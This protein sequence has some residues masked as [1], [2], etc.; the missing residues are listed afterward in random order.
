[1]ENFRKVELDIIVNASKEAVWDLTFN[2]FGEVNNFNPLIEG[3]HFTS[4]SKGEVGCERQCDLDLKGNHLIERIIDAQ[5]HDS[6][7]LE[8][9]G[10]AM[11]MMEKMFVKQA[12][13]EIGP[14][15]TRVRLIV[16]FRSKP[17]FMGFLM[18][19]MMKR[20]LFDMLRGLKY[21]LETGELVTKENIKAIKRAYAG[22][23]EGQI[24]SGLGVGASVA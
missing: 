8:I 23:S 22:L 5:G 17:A 1:M 9:I 18:S 6:F 21:H 11:P 20:M 13:E 12:F 15:K 10:G 3:S 16:R 24:F 4:M 2:R 14:N 7:E 19:M